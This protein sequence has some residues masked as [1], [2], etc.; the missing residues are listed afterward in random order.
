[1]NDA[2]ERFAAG[3]PVLIGSRT[4]GAPFVAV[5]AERI[6]P[7]AL[8][9]LHGLGGGMVVLALGSDVAERLALEPSPGGKPRAA[10]LPFTASIDAVKVAD[11][12]WSLRDRALTMR[13]AAEP[14]T[15]PSD[16][17]SPGHVHPVR[18]ADD[19][20]IQHGGAVAASLELA[21]SVGRPAAVTLC[22]VVN[23]AGARVALTRSPLERPLARLPLA[24]VDELQ[25]LARARAATEHAVECALPTRAGRFRAVAHAASSGGEPTIALVHGDL[26]PAARAPVHVHS[27]CILG[28]VFGSLL[29]HCR[30]ELDRAVDEISAT[31]A[32]VLLY[33]KPAPSRTFHCAAPRPIDASLL[34]GLL[35]RLGLN[36]IRLDGVDAAL[37]AELRAFGF[38]VEHD[39]NLRRVA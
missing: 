33:V 18:I 36:R 23:R 17:T 4:D 27:G 31:G 9:R 2:A 29:C 26:D 37:A 21:R 14:R 28:D 1:M 7:D 22:A 19:H 5:A 25:A 10:G 24:G 13:A 39:D 16:F 32:G 8:E 6:D 38:D 15:G 30:A 20:L 34:A 12:G 11:G 3:D 35:V